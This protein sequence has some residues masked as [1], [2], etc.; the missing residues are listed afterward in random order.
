MERYR[1]LPYLYSLLYQ[2]N[3]KGDTVVT[4]LFYEWPEDLNTHDIDEQ[5]MWGS[6][7]MIVPALHPENFV[8]FYLPPG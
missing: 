5:F 3:Q 4:P 2:A 1:L 8:Q 6:G 7:F